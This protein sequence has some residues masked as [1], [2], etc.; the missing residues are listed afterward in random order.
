MTTGSQLILIRHSNPEI[1]QN[2]PAREWSISAEGRRRAEKIAERLAEHQPEVIF[3]SMEPKAQQ[4]AEILSEILGLEFSV[5]DGLHEHERRDVPFHS[6]DDFRSLVRGLF[7]KPDA[8]VFGEETGAQASERFRKSVDSILNS[9]G[10]KKV[11]LVS[12]GTV[13]SLYVS[14]LTGI[15]GYSLWEGLGL[16]S[17][18]VL[19]IHKRKLLETVNIN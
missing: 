16:P 4:T 2:L 5:V 15:D 18:V 11:T 8:L 13:I 3:S 19:D 6:Q 17:I 9:Y 10:D 1:V 14:W 12:H 7:E